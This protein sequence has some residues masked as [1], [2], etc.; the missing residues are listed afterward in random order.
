M[1]QDVNLPPAIEIYYYELDVVHRFTY[2]GSNISDNLSLDAEMNRCI[3]KAALALAH[4]AT[5]V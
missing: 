3:G 1:G 4:L 5:C 2:L